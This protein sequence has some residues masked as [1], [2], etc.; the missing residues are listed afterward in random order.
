MYIDDVRMRYL[1]ASTTVEN[2]GHSNFD[3]I[4]L[5]CGLIRLSPE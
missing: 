2:E 3:K 5:H 1:E 4:D